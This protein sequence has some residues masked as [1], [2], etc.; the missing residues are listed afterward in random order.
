M[1]K[2][3]SVN[4]NF[5]HREQVTGTVCASRILLLR[6]RRKNKRE[7]LSN[8]FRDNLIWE[9]WL[10]FGNRLHYPHYLRCRSRVFEYSELP[11]S[12]RRFKRVSRVPISLAHLFTPAQHSLRVTLHET[13]FTRCFMGQ[14]ALRFVN[15]TIVINSRPVRG[16]RPYAAITALP[17]RQSANCAVV[18][19]SCPERS[20]RGINRGDRVYSRIRP[21]G[22]AVGMFSRARR[23][24]PGKLRYNCARG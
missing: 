21:R 23:Q 5:F 2:H 24:V 8:D 1:R 19:P 9:Q 17:R 4:C 3:F 18:D 7:N 14:I 12:R 10:P 13:T 15:P 11:A 20:F 22:R 16:D 6:Q